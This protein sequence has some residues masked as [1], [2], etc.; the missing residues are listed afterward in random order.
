M[1]NLY[2][3]QNGYS[4]MVIDKFEQQ[5]PLTTKETPGTLV[6]AGHDMRVEKTDDDDANIKLCQHALG[7]LL[8]LVTRTRPDLTWAS[9]SRKSHDPKSKRGG[10]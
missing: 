5:R 2:L 9:C 7:T 6:H 3:H 8:W 10:E 4:H 1:T